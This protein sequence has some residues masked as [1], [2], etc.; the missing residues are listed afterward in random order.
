VVSDGGSGNDA[1][2]VPTPGTGQLNGTV[3]GERPYNA[4]H[5]QHLLVKDKDTVTI[6]AR[7][8]DNAKCRSHPNC[9]PMIRIK[10]DR[11]SR[12]RQLRKERKTYPVTISYFTYEIDERLRYV[13]SQFG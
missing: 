2:L 12:K 11:Q 9:R 5:L 13:A 3:R 8:K 4:A 6:W 7:R 10:K 1:T